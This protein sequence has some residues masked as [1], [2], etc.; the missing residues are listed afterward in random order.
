MA[1]LQRLAAGGNTMRLHRPA[2]TT[3]SLTLCTLALAACG[4]SGGGGGST[5]CQVTSVS[6]TASAT[7]VNPG[8]KT[9]LTASVTSTGTCGG[10]VS[11]GASP[12]GG[13]LTTSGLTA[14]FSATEA[15]GYT[16][17]ATSTD[18][19]SKAGSVVVN[20]TSSCGT[21]NGTVVTHTAD[22]TAD[23]TWAG[24]G[25]THSVPGSFAIKAP[26][27]LTIQPCALVALAPGVEIL[28]EGDTSGN[29]PAKLFAAGTDATTGFIAFLPASA[30]QPWGFLHGVNAQSFIELDYTI[31]SQA[32]AGGNF[33][34]YAAIDMVGTG[35][36]LLPAA[37][38]S[39]NH[40]LIDHPLGAGI[41]LE[42][43]SSFTSD[44]GLLMIQNAAD[45][46]LEMEMMAVGSIPPFIG[47]QNAHDDALVIGPSSNIFGDLTFNANIPI[48]IQA[49][50]NVK[51]T[52]GSN[53]TVTLTVLPGAE[54][55]FDAVTTAGDEGIRM[56]FGGTGNPGL[57][58]IGQLIAQ[59]TPSQPIVFT[60]AAAT[61]AAGDWA[62]LQLL[63]PGATEMAYVTIEYAGAPGGYVSANCRPV[64]TSD[65]A[66]LLIG[67]ADFIPSTSI[68]ANSTIQYSAGYGIDAVWATTSPNDP[69]LT[70]NGNIFSNNA[71]CAQ[72]Y[73]A[74]TGASCPAGGGCTSP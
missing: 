22:I 59:G 43:G 51:D 13:S 74:V 17:T 12:S 64:N 47:Q 31:L 3:L 5:T 16:L 54:I 69:V 32:G 62:G 18:D 15:Q 40:L 4:G 1:L 8:Q 45:Y 53:A 63:E 35:H 38:L 37:V 70:G 56:V 27:T 48:H 49:D 46:P 68:L 41:Y 24:A 67:N 66:A 60:S 34:A 57:N 14:T 55:R 29:R 7:S 21:P 6:V 71:R 11:W 50:V 9:N 23:E 36:F 26:A 33:S 19:T 52:S 65:Q 30:N 20:V 25:V 61:P 28:V 42:S 2:T 58:P 39:V 10:G 44:S 72:T 73:N